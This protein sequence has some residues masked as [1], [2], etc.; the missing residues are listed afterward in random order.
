M[1]AT[2]DSDPLSRPSPT[3]W[4]PYS[5]VSAKTSPAIW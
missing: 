3:I 2:A 4:V 1:T 5:A